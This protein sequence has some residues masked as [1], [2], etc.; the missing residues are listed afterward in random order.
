MSVDIIIL[1]VAKMMVDLG[2]YPYLIKTAE[3]QHRDGHLMHGAFPSF[4]VPPGGHYGLEYNLK[5]VPGYLFTSKRPG[6]R[7]FL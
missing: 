2:R 6:A 4:M 5:L 3:M 7:P 1:P